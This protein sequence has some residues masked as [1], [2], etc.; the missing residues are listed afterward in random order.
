[1]RY[2]ERQLDVFSILDSSQLRI[3]VEWLSLSVVV[4]T[5]NEENRFL[6]CLFVSF[7]RP[8]TH[9]GHISVTL[10]RNYR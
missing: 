3:F 5:V 1:M 2:R 10:L 9:D 7:L 8:V 6:F 4:F